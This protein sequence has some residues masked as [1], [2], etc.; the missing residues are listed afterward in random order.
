MYACMHVFLS[1]CMCV[2]V[3]CIYMYTQLYIRMCTYTHV[4]TKM[5][6][7]TYTYLHM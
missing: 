3:V 6:A 5:C 2:Y 7:D 1:V 4:Y